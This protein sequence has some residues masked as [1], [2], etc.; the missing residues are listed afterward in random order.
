MRKGKSA[1]PDQQNPKK[2]RRSSKKLP[3]VEV[4]PDCEVLEI[5]WQLVAQL[6]RTCSNS[7]SSSSKAPHA[8]SKKGASKKKSK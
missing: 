2:R 3:R 8:C 6:T 7:L 5:D 1:A 4:E